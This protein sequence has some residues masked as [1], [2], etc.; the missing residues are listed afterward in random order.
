MELPEPAADV[1]TLD[2]LEELLKQLGPDSAPR[3]GV[4]GPAEMVA[5]CV[6]FVD[7]CLGRT[8]VS[9]PLRVLARLLGPRFL[10][11]LLSRS[12]EEAPREVSTLRSLR[13][14]GS[15]GELAAALGALAERWQALRS[16]PAEH[17]H[18]LYGPMR[19]E[20]V[21]ALVRHHTAHHANQFGLLAAR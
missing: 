7:L 2:R 10:R 20:D 18:P 15:G 5:H 3:W 17:R 8:R 1:P 16:L 6:A 14:A 4:M 19:Q 12:V 13:M 21:H 11:R 9:W